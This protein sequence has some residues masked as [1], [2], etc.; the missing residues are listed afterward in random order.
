[1]L[2]KLLAEFLGTALI[3]TTVLG[4]GFMVSNLGADSAL[5]LLMIAIAVGSVLLVAIATLGPI[6]GAH[7]NPIVSLAQLARKAQQLSDTL[8]YILSQLAGAIA[9]SLLAAAMFEKAWNVSGVERLSAGAFVGEVV[10]SAGLVLLI[11]LLIR[12]Q[13]QNLIGPAVALWITAGHL[14]TSSSAFANPAVTIGRIFSAAVSGISPN[15]ALG[16]IAAQIVGLGLALMIFGLL[17]VK[18]K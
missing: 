17:K 10:A 1:V 13:L 6:S 12:G 5:S 18:G 15:S 11:L 9:G 2:S 16:F 4:A 7:F 14:F 8:L 3:V